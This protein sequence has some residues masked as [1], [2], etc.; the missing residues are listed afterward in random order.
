MEY[1]FQL[2]LDDLLTE[3]KS[4]RACL[5]YYMKG[6]GKEKLEKIRDDFLKHEFDKVIL[7]GR[8]SNYY[9]TYVPFFMLNSNL[10]KKV[11]PCEAY[12]AS[13]FLNYIIPRK[14][15]P[16]LLFILISGSGQ[17]RIIKDII[18]SLKAVGYPADN[19]WAITEQENSLLT[20]E[21][22][23][24][25][26]LKV[27]KEVIHASKSYI[28]TIFVFYF[29]CLAMQNKDFCSFQVEKEARNLISEVQLYLFQWQLNTQN[30][31]D[32]LGEQSDKFFFAS[33]GSSQA[34]SNQ[35]R[36]ICNE[37]A[38]IFAESTTLDMFKFGPL[39]MVDPSFRAIIISGSRFLEN[40]TSNIMD[41][42]NSIT[43]KLGQG[44][45][46]LITNV[47]EI[48]AQVRANPL[49]FVF[50]HT[51]VNPYLAPIFEL[52]VLQFLVLE[53]AKRKKIIS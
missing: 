51:T 18:D 35:I 49:V 30:L 28:H 29:L 25:L 34:A 39:Q 24:V 16:K 15:E 38:N 44:R 33:R 27:G 53:I 13:E 19:L 52:V 46:I 42:V 4:L 37:Y 36:L 2:V 14:Y 26:F 45:V 50:E 47:R 41:L 21:A 1:N 11:I 17:S 43:S 22:E 7:I 31:I 23:H 10:N 32:F 8:G 6:E 20:R 9:T 12:E 3:P 40:E 48:A 5:N